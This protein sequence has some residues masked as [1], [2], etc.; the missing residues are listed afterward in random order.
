MGGIASSW[1][2][3]R[4]VTGACELSSLQSGRGDGAPDE[5]TLAWGKGSLVSLDSLSESPC[6]F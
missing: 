5:G 6:F 2:R 1:K 3:R 4:F